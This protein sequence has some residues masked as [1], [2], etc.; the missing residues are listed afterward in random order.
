ML[1]QAASESSQGQGG[2]PY[3]LSAIRMHEP[4][5]TSATEIDRAWSELRSSDGTLALSDVIG[6]DTV[7]TIG[8]SMCEEFEKPL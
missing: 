8:I 3:L 5:Y 2:V 6:L 7:R 1:T 4:G